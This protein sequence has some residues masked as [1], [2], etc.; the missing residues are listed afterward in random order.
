MLL[1]LNR[2]FTGLQK[3]FEF[4]L[5]YVIKSNNTT[6]ILQSHIYFRKKQIVDIININLIKDRKK[7]YT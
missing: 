2:R 3:T 6:K 4:C 1:N 5:K 7:I